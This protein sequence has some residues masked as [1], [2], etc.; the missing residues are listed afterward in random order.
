MACWR[1]QLKG[2]FMCRRTYTGSTVAYLSRTAR[3]N[4][5][6]APAIETMPTFAPRLGGRQGSCLPAFQG[7]DEQ[8]ILTHPRA[9][10]LGTTGVG[11]LLRWKRNECQIYT[12][13]DGVYTTTR[14]LAREAPTGWDKITF[15]ED[16]RN[17]QPGSRYCR[18]VS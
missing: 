7:V 4:K 3:T 1:W 13:V 6:R 11:W 8:A 12:D 9:R 14:V 5:G 16:A 17:G 18:S 2:H 15:R 10:R